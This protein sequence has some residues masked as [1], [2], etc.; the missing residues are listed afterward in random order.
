MNSRELETIRDQVAEAAQVPRSTWA[1]AARDLL[2]RQRDI[3]VRKIAADTAFNAKD[4]RLHVNAID[5]I[6]KTFAPATVAAKRGPGRPKKVAEPVIMQASP[7]TSEDKILHRGQVLC[8]DGWRDKERLAVIEAAEAAL[9][10]FLAATEMVAQDL[11]LAHY[12]ELVSFLHQLD[13]C[14]SS[15]KR[16]ISR[17]LGRIVTP[18]RKIA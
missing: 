4:A 13:E 8:Y 1:D 3:H 9:K 7:E 6:I 12:Q 15:A 18:Q 11:S 5:D 16:V 17:Q 2:E 10:E 14:E